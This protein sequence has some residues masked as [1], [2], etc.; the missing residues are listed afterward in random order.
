MARLVALFDSYRAAHQAAQGL[1]AAGQPPD[2]TYLLG[3]ADQGADGMEGFYPGLTPEQDTGGGPGGDDP[4]SGP[5]AG[6]FAVTGTDSLN[7]AR[8]LEERMARL[9][10]GA[11]EVHRLLEEVERG[12][13]AAVFTVPG[14]AERALRLL[15]EGGALSV[16]QIF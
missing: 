9:G 2:V 11:G 15:A 12:R 13:V 4:F 1:A 5:L 7:P 6:R 14:S 10:L 8:S 3:Q 16:E